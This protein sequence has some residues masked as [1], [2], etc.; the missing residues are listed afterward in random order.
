MMLSDYVFCIIIAD[1]NWNKIIRIG[2]TKFPEE[3]FSTIFFAF[4][5]G[6]NTKKSGFVHFGVHFPIFPF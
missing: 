1:D 2:I 5:R 3:F 6:N 4:F